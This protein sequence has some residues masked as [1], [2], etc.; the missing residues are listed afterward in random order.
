MA[1]LARP[2]SLAAYS[3]ALNNA[4]T[5]VDPSGLAPT[6]ATGGG[7]P[8]DEEC[9]QRNNQEAYDQYV[10]NINAG[11]ATDDSV[12][13]SVPWTP[14]QREQLVAGF[15]AS[16]CGGDDRSGCRG[17]TRMLFYCQLERGYG[18]VDQAERASAAG[19]AAA[20]AFFSAA[21]SGVSKV[22]QAVGARFRGS[23]VGPGFQAPR[24]SIDRQGRLSNG[25]YSVSAETMAPHKTGSGS[26]GKSQFLMK[27]DAESVVLDA[28]AFAD[29]MNLWVGNKAKVHVTNGP[30]GVVGRTGELTNWVTVTR[31]SGGTV[32]G[33]P[34]GAPR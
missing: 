11:I 21:S 23:S 1:D 15:L 2:Q 14:Q 22:V 3:Y 17:N 33:W 13:G 27:V 28:A 29:E 16:P 4:A 9:Q 25:R 6:D 30:V 20:G 32:H 12:I 5:L 7:R 18:C 31:T 8:C 19:D 10:R 24:V 34:S 26:S